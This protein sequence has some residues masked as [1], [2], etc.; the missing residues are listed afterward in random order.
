MAEMKR[1]GQGHDVKSAGLKG[2]GGIEGWTI[3]GMTPKTRTQGQIHLHQ[4]D[5]RR[6]VRG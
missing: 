4:E 5:L 6:V 1:G 3:V 2:S